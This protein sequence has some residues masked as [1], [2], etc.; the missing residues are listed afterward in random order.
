[1]SEFD[2]G[3]MDVVLDKAA[4]DALMSKEGDVWHP[5]PIVVQG[6]HD[7][8]QHI[9]RILV[10]H[11]GY[12]LQISFAQ[13]H[14]RKKYLLGWHYSDSISG[15][16]HEEAQMTERPTQL[17]DYSHEYEW[18]LRYEAIQKERGCFYHYLYIMTKTSR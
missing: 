2:D 6:A 10:P 9:A 14:F 12:F 5:D 13:P 15:S 7:M 3:S 1:M 17:E 18:M 11:C 8:C 4:M 16:N